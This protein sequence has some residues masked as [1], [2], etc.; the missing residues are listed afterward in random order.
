MKSKFFLLGIIILGGLFFFGC[1]DDDG[2]IKPTNSIVYKLDGRTVQYGDPSAIAIDLSEDGHVDFTIFVELTANSL[3]D[4]LYAGMNPIGANLIKSGPP[5]DENFLSMGLLVAENSGEII[6]FEVKQNQQWTSDF[7]ALAIRN[8][9]TNGEISYEGNWAD[10]V[11]IVGIQHK[12]NETT[13]FGWLRIKFDKVT[14]IVTLI[15]YAY[16][17]IV[18]QPILAGANSN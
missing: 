14:E 6:D 18:N 8:T 17:S 2:I 3:G 16:D 13:H 15:D 10:S 1:D 12:I 9:Y 4:R 7:G 5:I 11:Q